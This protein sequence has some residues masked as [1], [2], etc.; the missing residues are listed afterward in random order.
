M[1]KKWCAKW[2]CKFYICALSVLL[3]TSLL[4]ETLTLPIPI[5]GYGEGFKRVASSNRPC[6]SMITTKNEFLVCSAL[7]KNAAL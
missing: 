5:S 3:A 1:D 2:R 6:D 7:S 4:E